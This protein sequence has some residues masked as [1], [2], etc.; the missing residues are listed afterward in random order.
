MLSIECPNPTY[1]RLIYS[2]IEKKIL[3]NKELIRDA[4]LTST[5][6][7]E[8]VCSAFDKARKY[9]N[10]N[11]NK[12]SEKTRLYQ[13]IAMLENY[14]EQENLFY[15]KEELLM[16]NPYLL[17]FIAI[18]EEIFNHEKY[19][20]F[21]T[22]ELSEAITSYCIGEK[23]KIYVWRDSYIWRNN[24]FKN[25]LSNGFHGDLHLSQ[26]D[27]SGREYKNL[28]GFN[29]SDTWKDVESRNGFGAP[30]S[31]WSE[32]LMTNLKYAEALGKA[33]MPEIVNWKDVLKKIGAVGTATAEAMF[34]DGDD[35]FGLEM[36]ENDFLFGADPKDLMEQEGIT[37]LPLSIRCDSERVFFPYFKD[38]K[39]IYLIEDKKGK[40]E[41][42]FKKG[43][44]SN[45]RFIPSFGY[46]ESDLPF[47]LEGTYS[48]FARDRSV[49]PKLMERFIQKKK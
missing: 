11:K 25:R 31:F 33:K 44:Y 15:D 36:L 38:G 49:L 41:S 30:W 22:K 5:I 32:F 3:E 2:G 42:P 21:S 46:E 40:M 37:G 6:C 23:E 26:W 17:A 39:L 16:Q 29:V 12:F 27:V 34:G 47:L 7:G 45:L 18:G 4:L 8:S 24:N 48:L 35:D 10:S 20:F 19:E 13:N 14:L 9:L 1:D 28:F 43:V